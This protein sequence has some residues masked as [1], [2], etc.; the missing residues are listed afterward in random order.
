MRAATYS[1]YS[2]DLQSEASIADQVEVC[3]RLIES[4]DWTLVATYEDRALSGGSPFRPGYQKML[5]D[6]EAGVF[7]VIVVEALDRLSRKLADIAALHDRLQ[8]ADVAIHT[9]ATGEVTAMHV[10]MLGT[11]AQ[12]Y[13]SDLREKTRRGQLGRALKGRIPG[14]KAYGLDVVEGG[15]GGVRRINEAEAAVVRRIFK[16]FAA[17]ESPRAIARK[18]NAEGVPGP[19]GRPWRDTTIRGQVDR[20][21]GLLNNALYV[22]RLEWNRCS[23]VKN[24]R[25]GKRVARVN[26]REQWEIVEVPELRIVDDTLWDAVKV[27][28]EEVRIEIGRDESGNPLNRAHRQTYLLSGLLYC[29]VCGGRYAIAGRDR[30]GCSNHRAR[31]DCTNST[32]IRRDDIERRVLSGLEE[33]LMAPELVAAFVDEYRA[34]IERMTRESEVTRDRLTRECAEVERKIERMLKA[35]EDGM[36]T[37]SM[38]DRMRELEARRGEL[39]RAI[40]DA[41]SPGPVRLHPRLSDVYKAKVAD[42]QRALDDDAIRSE[43]AT[44][45]RGQI[46]RIVLTPSKV[47]NLDAELHGDLAGVLALCE[48]RECERPGKALPGRRLSVVAGARNHR[49]L[50]LSVEV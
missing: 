29:G 28:Q 38:K 12:L 20:G 47:G 27:R 44:I 40:A 7:D 5:A 31:G 1:R 45:L 13:L 35:I 50:T 25:T 4:K 39:D 23:Y 43:A 21:T 16:A 42:L 32:T 19:G 22:G 49:E 18:L 17:G 3:R 9:V 36:Y 24:P 34:E 15:E 8:F 30:Y 41:P 2:S 33:R 11:M 46:E 26:P 37:P 10:G 14:G 6:A 48:G